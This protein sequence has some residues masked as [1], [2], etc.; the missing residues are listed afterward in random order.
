MNTS[1]VV[2]IALI[3]TPIMKRRRNP[4]WRLG[5]RFVSKIESR[6]SPTPPTKDPKT[7][8]E[9]KIR[10]LVRRCGINLQRIKCQ[11][12]GVELP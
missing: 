5:C 3:A 1:M 7:A 6:T 10:S 8:S 12:H 4:L 9:P 2:K 11:P